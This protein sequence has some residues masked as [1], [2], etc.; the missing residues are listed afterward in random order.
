MEEVTKPRKDHDRQKERN[1]IER[2]HI[3]DKKALPR[4]GFVQALHGG[5]TKGRCQVMGIAA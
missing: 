2:A 1:P 5:Q 3:K 4:L